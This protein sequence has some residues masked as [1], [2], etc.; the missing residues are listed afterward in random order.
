MKCPEM[1]KVD[2]KTG[3]AFTLMKNVLKLALGWFC[4]SVTILKTN[5]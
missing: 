3:F 4:V 5:Y 2:R 1:G